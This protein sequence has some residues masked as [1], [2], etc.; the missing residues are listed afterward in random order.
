VL[1]FIVWVYGCV[2][3]SAHPPIPCN[4][5]PQQAAALQALFGQKPVEGFSLLLDPTV[6][7]ELGMARVQVLRT[8]ARDQAALALIETATPAPEPKD[9]PALT[10]RQEEIREKAISEILSDKQQKR[11]QQLLA[12]Q[13]GASLLLKKEMEQELKLNNTQR[14]V[15]YSIHQETIQKVKALPAETPATA[16]SRKAKLRQIRL[17]GYNHM[18]RALTAEQRKQFRALLGPPIFL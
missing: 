3:V 11:L 1:C 9:I 17:A 13:Q 15:L 6:Q 8:M 2:G 5:G 10:K 12:Q 14:Y 18:L 7:R 4:S 16:T